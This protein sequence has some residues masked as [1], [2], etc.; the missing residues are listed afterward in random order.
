MIETN[1]GVWERDYRQ[2]TQEPLRY[3]PQSRL[4]A[5]LANARQPARTPID[6]F[7]AYVNGPRLA[8]TNW[9]EHD[10]F[11]WWMN[12]PY[13]QL[14]QWAFDVLSIPAMSAECERVFSQTRRL[15]TVDRN[16]LSTDM[17]EALECMKHW[18]DAGLLG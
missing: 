9:S 3:N 12:S 2:N 18:W 8:Y 6:E 17:M 16:R 15:M 11:S 7:T 1:R 14:R 13:P 5:Y 10:I 4:D